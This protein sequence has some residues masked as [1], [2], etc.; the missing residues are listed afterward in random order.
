MSTTTA[1]LN[2]DIDSAE[3]QRVKRDVVEVQTSM[4]TYVRAALV[5]FRQTLSIDQRRAR[6]AKGDRKTI[7][8]PVNFF[9]KS[10]KQI[11]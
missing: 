4:K 3:L 11:S 10:S 9:A 5:H 8:R 2:T 1:Q 6:F 7:G